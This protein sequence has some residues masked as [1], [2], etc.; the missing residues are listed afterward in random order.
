[1]YISAE[2]GPQTAL[3]RNLDQCRLGT[4]G[5]LVL[6]AF[7]CTLTRRTKPKSTKQ[8]NDSS[9][10]RRYGRW[11]SVVRV[12]ERRGQNPS[13]KNLK[14]MMMEADKYTSIRI[15]SFIDQNN[16]KLFLA[17]SKNILETPRIMKGCS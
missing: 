3:K 1:M 11:S 16:R 5:C 9:D 6:C 17:D 10:N 8:L 15:W 4:K 7:P 12:P 13:P 14:M 2:N